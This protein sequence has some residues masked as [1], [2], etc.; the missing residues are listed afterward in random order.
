M[1][2][3]H[4]R[5]GVCDGLNPKGG[6]IMRLNWGHGSYS[7]LL[8]LALAVSFFLAVDGEISA[9]TPSPQAAGAQKLEDFKLKDGSKISLEYSTKAR[10][11]QGFE[12]KEVKPA[13]GSE[14][15]DVISNLNPWPAS[16]EATIKF[17]FKGDAGEVVITT[18]KATVRA[19]ANGQY[20]VKLADPA[21][22]LL[23]SVPGDL[24]NSMDA[25]KP[26]SLQKCEI[27][28]VPL[29][30]SPGFKSW[31]TEVPVGQ[32]SHVQ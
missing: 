2:G 9:E 24:N 29:P 8:W 6:T 5:A 31:T 21:T 4:F 18:K 15:I 22:K 10:Q 27:T 32:L 3:G 25:G 7:W 20:A 11:L 19:D 17:T 28:V 23:D 14:E 26:L 1:E 16:I 12:I 30:A 13:K